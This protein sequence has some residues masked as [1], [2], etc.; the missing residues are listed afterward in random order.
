MKLAPRSATVNPNQPTHN[1]ENFERNSE[2]RRSV[3]MLQVHR[4]LEGAPPARF[5]PAV[6]PVR[7]PCVRK[8]F[9]RKSA[10]GIEAREKYNLPLCEPGLESSTRTC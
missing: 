7:A 10:F 3:G 5:V 6:F 2:V 4:R 9:Q 8:P 1:F